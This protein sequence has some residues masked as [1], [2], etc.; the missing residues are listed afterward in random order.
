[1]LCWG[2]L[3]LSLCCCPTAAA[4]HDKL[5]CWCTW[6]HTRDLICVQKFLGTVIRMFSNTNP[7]LRRHE[8]GKYFAC[9]QCKS[10]CS[11]CIRSQKFDAAG[12][13]NSSQGKFHCPKLHTANKTC[14]SVW[15]YTRCIRYLARDCFRKRI[16]QIVPVY[17]VGCRMLSD[18]FCKTQHCP[19]N[20]NSQFGS[21]EISRR[22]FPH[23]WSISNLLDS[24]FL[25]FAQHVKQFFILYTP[26]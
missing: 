15:L 3:A 18:T 22:E 16:P 14:I 21:C 4:S 25:N 12:A 2:V 9:Q 17:G 20:F 23:I 5:P 6:I 11:V 10:T 26:V 19:N 1:M 8:L 13:G 24:F 7:I